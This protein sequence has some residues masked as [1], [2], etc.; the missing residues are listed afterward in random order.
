[1]IGDNNLDF[2]EELT[3][4]G[5]YE[6]MESDLL[7][8]I[9]LWN[10]TEWVQ[11]HFAKEMFA[12]TKSPDMIIPLDLTNINTPTIKIRYKSASG[13]GGPDY[14]W[15]DF[16]AEEVIEKTIIPVS[17]ADFTIAN[18]A[19]RGNEIEKLKEDDSNY[20]VFDTGDYGFIEFDALSN[21]SIGKRTLF[22]ESNGYYYYDKWSNKVD[23]TDESK[24]YIRNVF[25][26]K[27]LNMRYFTPKI[28]KDNCSL[29]SFPVSGNKV[30]DWGKIM[31]EFNPLF[32]DFGSHNS[33]NTDYVELKVTVGTGADVILKKNTILK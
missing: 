10:G 11:Q 1:M 13:L 20:L 2:L 15:M 25:S 8:N 16:S 17:F 12:S 32:E 6:Q 18:E 3:L 4:D 22:T 21:P 7:N 30:L 5:T 9:W 14:I 24:R 26:N 31:K 19:E 23:L 33:L 29:S 27:V 28:F